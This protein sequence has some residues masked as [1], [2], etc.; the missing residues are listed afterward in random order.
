MNNIFK[1]S[2]FGMYLIAK[3]KSYKLTP[4]QYK[5]FG[6]LYKHHRFK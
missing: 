6:H 2:Q 1:G 4:E 3:I 5:Y